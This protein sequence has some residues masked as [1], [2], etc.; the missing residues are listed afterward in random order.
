M[1]IFPVAGAFRPTITWITKSTIPRAINPMPPN[2]IPLLN[3][4]LGTV[5]PQELLSTH[6]AVGTRPDGG[7]RTAPNRGK[8]AHWRL[9]LSS[10][11]TLAEAPLAG[12]VALPCVGGPRG[13]CDRRKPVLG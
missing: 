10:G 9:A 8:F 12:R 3:P 7:M 11:L 2:L 1:Y 5:H 6:S 4:L 13:L